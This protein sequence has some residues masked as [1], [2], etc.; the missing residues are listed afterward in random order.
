MVPTDDTGVEISS[1]VEIW[2]AGRGASCDSVGAGWE[3]CLAGDRRNAA[4]SRYRE[5]RIQVG[6]AATRSET[7]RTQLCSI[8]H[9]RQMAAHRQLC[10]G[11]KQRSNFTGTIVEME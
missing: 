11:T 8:Q 4:E 7:R 3:N 1:G 10:Q 9:R 6:R 2:S 5:H